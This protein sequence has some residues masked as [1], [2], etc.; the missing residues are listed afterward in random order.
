MMELHEYD[1][2]YYRFLNI[3]AGDLRISITN[4]CNMM[5]E[6]CHNEGQNRYAKHYLSAEKIRHIIHNA[7]KY[8]LSKVR[9]T[10][11]E[12][13]IHP[14][15]HQICYMISKELCINNLGINTN[16][17]ACDELIN[18]C[19]E[20]FLQQVVIGMDYFDGK[21]SKKSPI[22]PSSSE[23]KELILFLKQLG[24]NVQVAVVYS[25]NEND[26]FRFVEWGAKNH[27]LIKVLE[28]ED[29]NNPN[30]V[31][32]KFDDL[33]MSV[34]NLY[35]LKTGLTADLRETYLYDQNSKVLF[36][37]SHCN[38]KE[39]AVCRNMHLR[40]NAEGKARICLFREDAFDLTT[41]D[42]DLNIR[43]AI[44]NMGTPPSQ[45]II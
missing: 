36:F 27:V 32:Q 25:N 21:V 20:G 44:T 15:I 14:D 10:G 28:E 13:L 1:E 34:Q 45:S 22:G 41:G 7:K 26:V 40:I 42:F 19:K 6:Y 8:G 43:K 30:F 29:Y 4:E 35:K 5:C 31:P 9:I 23:I 37:Q 2:I 24:V 12:P 38:R 16:G 17:F 3:P 39:C 11:G 33:I 18:L